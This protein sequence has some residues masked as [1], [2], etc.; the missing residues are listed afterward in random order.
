MEGKQS[1]KGT[2]SVRPHTYRANT[3]HM[4]DN[5]PMKSFSA[6][7]RN[8][9]STPTPS[10]RPLSAS[11]TSAIKSTS[12]THAVAEGSGGSTHLNHPSTIATTTASANLKPSRSATAVQDILHTYRTN[13]PSNVE[14]SNAAQGSTDISNGLTEDTDAP[15]VRNTALQSTG[16]ILK[17]G[18]FVS[19]PATHLLMTQSTHSVKE[20]PMVAGGDRKVEERVAPALDGPVTPVNGK[21]STRYSP[22]SSHLKSP[23]DPP[24]PPLPA[25]V[26]IG[27]P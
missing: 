3:S 18:R 5:S 26:P 7:Q 12:S 10:M 8:M 22:S 16:E 1:R 9:S 27:T 20:K 13:L 15:P 21:A 14:P 2:S 4:T 23:I 19:R 11:S 17:S 25:H 6:T 24:E